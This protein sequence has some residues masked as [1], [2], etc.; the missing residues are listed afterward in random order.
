MPR[1]P[2]GMTRKRSAY[3]F[4]RFSKGKETWTPL[5]SDYDVACAKLRQLREQPVLSSRGTVAQLVD[6]WLTAYIAT[7]RNEKGAKLARQRASDFLITFLGAKQV[8]RV[9][10]DDLRECRLWLGGRRLALQCVVHVLCDARCFFRWA[11]SGYIARSPFPKRLLPRIQER[12][13]DRLREDEVAA[14]VA[15]PEP[16]GS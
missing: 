3:Y 4:R 6:R 10:A 13:Q 5:G 15:L 11:E 12:P 8:T 9:T 14:L 7:A 1:L 2:R 16:W